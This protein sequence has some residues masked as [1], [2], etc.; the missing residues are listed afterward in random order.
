MYP[1]TNGKNMNFE[2]RMVAKSEIVEIRWKY[3]SF[4]VAPNRHVRQTIENI[5]RAQWSK[6]EEIVLK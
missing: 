3:V 2:G 6:I 4:L 1:K 5:M